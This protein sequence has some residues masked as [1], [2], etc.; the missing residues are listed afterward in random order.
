[1]KNEIEKYAK[2]LREEFDEVLSD[3]VALALTE[4][5]RSV[6]SSLSEQIGEALD[7]VSV[8]STAMWRNMLK[9]GWRRK[10]VIF[11]I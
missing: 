10:F 5:S 4:V 9:V 1:M 8:T 7:K 3:K 11:I 6:Y 2:E